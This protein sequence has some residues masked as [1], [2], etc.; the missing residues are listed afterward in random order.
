MD[1]FTIHNDHRRLLQKKGSSMITIGD[2]IAAGLRKYPIVWRNFLNTINLGA[3]GYRAR[4]VLLRAGNIDLPNS[5][6]IVILPY[7][8]N[9]IDQGKPSTFANGVMKIVRVLRKSK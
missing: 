5:T 7:I 9:N 3:S 4:Q 2:F 1:G 6:Q 8:T